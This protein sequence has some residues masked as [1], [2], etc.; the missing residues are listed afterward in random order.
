MKPRNNSFSPGTIECYSTRARTGR[1]AL[2]LVLFVL[3]ASA[4]ACLAALLGYI[5]LREIWA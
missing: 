1:L 2:T 5:E 4:C 3:L